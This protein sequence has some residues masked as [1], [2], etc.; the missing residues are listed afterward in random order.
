V[1]QREAR[2]SHPP[3]DQQLN[4]ER[5][6]PSTCSAL[7]V[8]TPLLQPKLRTDGFCSGFLAFGEYPDPA[9]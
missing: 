6:W 1:Q 5:Q 9:A 2:Q 3:F 8:R 4:Y 7:Q